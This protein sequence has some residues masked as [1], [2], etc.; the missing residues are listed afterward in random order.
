[1][2]KNK[3]SVVHR[4]T[5]TE[6]QKRWEFTCPSCGET[7]TVLT[8]FSPRDDQKFHTGHEITEDVETIKGRDS[9]TLWCVPCDRF[10]DKDTTKEINTNV[11]CSHLDNN[12]RELC[13]ELTYVDLTKIER[14]KDFDWKEQVNER[15]RDMERRD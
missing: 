12:G 5:E 4:I 15:I 7:Q 3:D 14:F 9:Q 1:M 11:Y 2:T 8:N 6:N 13:G 10:I